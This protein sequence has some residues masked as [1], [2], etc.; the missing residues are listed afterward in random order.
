[1]FSARLAGSYDRPVVAAASLLSSAMLHLT[2]DTPPAA[3]REVQ[4]RLEQLAR[5]QSP[6]NDAD[7][8]QAA[9]AH[10]GLLHDLLPATDALLKELIAAA[11]SPEQDVVHSLILK[12]QLAARTSADRYRLLLY[13]TSLILLGTL[14]YLGL[15]LRAR[16]IALRRRAA[17]EHVIASISMRFINA[18]PQNLDDEIERALAAMAGCIG[19]ERAYLVLRG[20]AP[21]L[22]AWCKVGMSFSPDR[23][24]RAPALAAQFDSAIDGIVHVPRVNCMPPGE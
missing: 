24:E 7:S 18:H 20:V 17:F 19:S 8:I 12:R 11:S 1:M 16:A 10:G 14:V 9:L 21:R 3:V 23:P 2:L 13:A 5:L 6:P 15:Q 4:D 22:H